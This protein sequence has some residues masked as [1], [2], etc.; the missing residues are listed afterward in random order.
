MSLDADKIVSVFN[1]EGFVRK[2]LQRFQIDEPIEDSVTG[3]KSGWTISWQLDTSIHCDYID[4]KS[5]DDIREILQ[6]EKQQSALQGARSAYLEKKCMKANKFDQQCARAL[7]ESKLIIAAIKKVGKVDSYSVQPD[8][9]EPS[10]FCIVEGADKITDEAEYDARCV[11][12]SMEE[13]SA[14]AVLTALQEAGTVV[15][16][17]KTLS[18]GGQALVA[19][20]VTLIENND[21]ANE[22][23]ASLAKET[24]AKE[25]EIQSLKARLDSMLESALLGGGEGGSG[26][27]TVASP[28]QFAKIVRV[29]EGIYEKI[30]RAQNGE[31]VTG[32][33]VSGPGAIS[34]EIIYF[35]SMI[36]LILSS[37]KG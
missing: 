19:E 24:L 7:S 5:A 29:L 2:F 31:A 35:K 36:E 6:T 11:A 33:P 8:F 28:K 25:N 22:K 18:A 14:K 15:E 3:K 20:H 1:E 10:M 13:A 32:L 21:E 26:N 37:V 9:Y 4:V 34:K 12:G 23:V 16:H 17:V 27:V 30:E